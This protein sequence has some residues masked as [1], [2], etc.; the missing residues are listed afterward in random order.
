MLNGAGEI[1]L[2]RFLDTVDNH[3]RFKIGK[4]DEDYFEWF[5]LDSVFC[6]SCDIFLER[7]YCHSFI[8]HLLF[9]DAKELR[10]VVDGMYVSGRKAL[11]FMYVVIYTR[12]L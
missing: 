9:L 5:F 3:D 6:F 2:V 11:R 7:L 1:S 8:F 10:V 4:G 12:S